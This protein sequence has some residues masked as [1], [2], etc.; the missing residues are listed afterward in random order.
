[1]ENKD[2]DD[3]VYLIRESEYH[4]WW[5]KEHFINLI[6]T[7]YSLDQY[8]IVRQDA[9]P[10]CF[11]TWAFPDARHIKEYL[12]EHKFPKDG[13]YGSGEDPWVIDFISLGGK[14][15]TTIGFRTVK[16]MLSRKGFNQFF[17]FR[18]ETSK[19]GFHKWS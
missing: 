16:S 17:W 11:A 13:F 19:L 9:R 7:P 1:M 10:I 6:K 3:I 12:L 8:L 4:N 14:R 18:T 2:I 15:N 5:G